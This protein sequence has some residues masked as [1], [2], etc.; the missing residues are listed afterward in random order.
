[1]SMPAAPSP[2]TPTGAAIGISTARPRGPAR[3]RAGR[4]T[5]PRPTGAAAPTARS[6]RGPGR[7]R[8]PS[9]PPGPDS[10]GSY[11]VSV[12]G[13]QVVANL[14]VQRGTVTFTGGPLYFLGTGS[15]FSNYVAAG[16]TAIFNTPFG[17]SG[18]PD[19]WGAGTAVYSGA[20]TCAG[21]FTLNE[22][23]LALGNNAALSTVRLDVGDVTGAKVV[24]LQVGGFHRA[25]AAQLS[26]PAGRQS[27]RRRRGQ[28]D[29][30]GADQHEREHERGQDPRREQQRDHL[31]R[32]ADQ[33]GRPDQDR[34]G[35]IGPERREREHLRQH[36][37]QRQYHRQRRHPATEQ[38]RGRG[39]GAQR[40]PDPQP[41]RHSPAGR[42]QPD[43]RRGA[44]DL[45]RRRLP[46]RRVQRTARHT[47]SDGQ[48][49]DRPWRR[50]QRGAICRQQRGGLDGGARP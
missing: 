18:S 43:W 40:H 47:E 28:S 31:L 50:C 29:I 48:L 27:Q 3:R 33:Y 23:T 1:M 44:D 2:P 9:S 36:Q 32:C 5:R 35:D 15:Y 49:A 17:G 22:G 11:T 4:G 46:D 16:A 38:D 34:S 6:P 30:H 24:T 7:N 45:G 13:T 21:Y 41:R 12:S 37:R 19:K 20:S 25:H 10:T 14:L 8:T 39:R 26:E 42:G